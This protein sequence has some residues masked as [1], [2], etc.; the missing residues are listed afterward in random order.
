VAENPAAKIPKSDYRN[1]LYQRYVT[2]FKTDNW[3]ELSQEQFEWYSRKYL[4]L[5]DGVQPTDPILD[6]GCGHGQFMQFLGQQGFLNVAGIDVSPEQ[7]E[8]AVRHGLNAELADA[9]EFLAAKAG[10]YRAI[11]ALDFVEHFHK[12][13]LLRLLPLIHRALQADGILVLQTPNGQGLFSQQ[14]I[15]ADLTH[16]TIFSPDSLRQLLALTGFDEICFYETGPVAKNFKG[17]VRLVLWRVIKSAA[18]A[19]RMIEAGKR[20]FIW[21]ENMIVRCGKIVPDQLS[22]GRRDPSYHA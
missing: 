4:P 17:V 12:D 8:I 7:I 18:N 15:H 21:T 10:S 19:V 11:V 20:Q 1:A 16:L 22:A 14:V 9:F 2:T 5:L 6:L 13:E 3:Q